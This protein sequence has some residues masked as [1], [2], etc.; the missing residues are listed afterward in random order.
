[1]IK[2]SLAGLALAVAISPAMSADLAVKNN[3]QYVIHKLYVSPSKSKKWGA[4]QLGQNSVAK[5]QEF[6]VRNI[7]AGVYDLKIVDQDDDSC[8]VENVDM[9]SSN[10]T[11]TLTDAIIE[12]CDDDEDE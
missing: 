11:W 6:T 12:T 8:L 1:M 4:D 3:S 5:G 10:I 2:S 9:S 7:P